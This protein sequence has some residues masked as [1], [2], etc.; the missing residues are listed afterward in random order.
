[1]SDFFQV[2]YSTLDKRLKNASQYLVSSSTSAQ[3]TSFLSDHCSLGNAVLIFCL[4]D[5][6]E[7]ALVELAANFPRCDEQ[8]LELNCT[9][10]SSEQIVLW[11]QICK[12]V[13]ISFSKNMYIGFSLSMGSPTTFNHILSSCV[14]DCPVF[15]NVYFGCVRIFQINIILQITC[16]WDTGNLLSSLNIYTIRVLLRVMVKITK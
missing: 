11:T 5:L 14:S 8:Y 3:C 1:M 13:N 6:V 16:T 2:Y 9:C 7:I 12:I 10:I 15:S 4:F